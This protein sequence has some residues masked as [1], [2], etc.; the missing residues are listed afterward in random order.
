MNES[1]TDK[2]FWRTYWQRRRDLVHEVPESILFSD[3]FK[4]AVDQ[5]GVTTA[6]DLGGFP[7]HYCVFLERYLGVKT[8][9][10]DF[11]IEREMLEDLKKLNGLG[12]GSIAVIEQDLLSKAP[13]CKFD[14]VYSLGL[15]EHFA[16]TKRMIEIHA[17]A[18]NE[19]GVLLIGI[20]NFRGLNGAFQRTF[21]RENYLKHDI[22]CMDPKLLERLCKELGFQEVRSWYEMK[23]GLWLEDP[24][25]KSG[26]ARFAEKAARF[27]GKA[28]F[29][30]VPV[31][32]KLGSPYIFVTARHR[33]ED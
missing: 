16:D 6:L 17:R 22:G 28:F 3:L 20:P 8:T 7:G 27:A 14:L 18:L 19:D 31:T 25:S 10:L 32:G 13:E 24:E 26:V 12:A 5:Y 29:R 30:L 1:L 21:D 23:F 33:R 15:I 4:T 9:L 11:V 2:E